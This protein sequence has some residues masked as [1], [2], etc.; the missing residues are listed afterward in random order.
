MKKVFLAL[1]LVSTASVF[2]QNVSVEKSITS[3]QIG[4]GTKFGLWINN[5]TRLSN[6]IALRSEIGLEN[7]IT[8]GSHYDNE[9]FILQPVLTL[10]P[11]YYYN[12][13]SRS[14]NSRKIKGN[15][16]NFI[17]VKT[18]YHPDW[19]VLNL[20]EKTT[21]LADLSIIPTWGLRRQLA[22]NFNFETAIG[23][24]YRVVYFKENSFNGNALNVDGAYNRNQYVPYLH[25]GVSYS[26]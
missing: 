10:E 22:E 12:L 16:G 17:S 26:L 8:V 25:V 7:D 18:S 13:F 15:S 6:T 3:L 4:G 14:S 5:E 21:R 19:F 9:G 1:I 2:A 20:D 24:G 23:I 11:K